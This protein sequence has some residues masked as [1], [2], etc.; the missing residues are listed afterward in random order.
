MRLLSL[1]LLVLPRGSIAFQ[2][3]VI[4]SGLNSCRKP[5]K[6][7]HKK[8]SKQICTKDCQSSKSLS[9]IGGVALCSSTLKD[10]DLDEMSDEN[11][12][13]LTDLQKSLKQYNSTVENLMNGIP[14]VHLFKPDGYKKL[15]P[16]QVED[17][18]LLFYDVFLIVNLLLSIS[19]WVTHRMSFEYLPS[20]FS[21]GCLFSILWIAAGLYHGSFLM[22]SVDGH[23]GSVDDRGGPKAAAALALNTFVNAVNLRLLFA[24]VVAFLQHRQVGT[25][26]GEQLLPLEIG[27]GLILMTSWRA[28]HSSI[29]PRI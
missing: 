26:P 20:A 3:Y 23:Y 15:P 5:F 27:F 17:T 10:D 7:L 24:L 29:T 9:Q 25:D 28:L 6:P 18:N 13:N 16:M 21:E 2:L 1:V 4:P 14:F 22:S 11:L 12:E 8:Q 19:F